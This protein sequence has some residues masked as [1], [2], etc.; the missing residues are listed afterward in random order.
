LGFLLV[1]VTG[2]LATFPLFWA[3]FALAIFSL[4]MISYTP[5]A[6]AFFADLSPPSLRGIYLSINSQCWAIGYFIGP[7]LGGWTLDQSLFII[8]S[9]WLFAAVTIIFGILILQILER[10]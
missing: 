9:F 4:P 3:I 10:I 1:W 8:H 7:A 5:S 6:S 2:F